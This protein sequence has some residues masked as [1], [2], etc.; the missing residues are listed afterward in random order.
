MTLSFKHITRVDG[1]IKVVLFHVMPT[2]KTAK[3]P[4]QARSVLFSMPADHI[5]FPRKHWYKFR[6]L[7]CRGR[8]VRSVDI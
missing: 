2:F 8:K 5:G 1:R 7:Y 3:Q 4:L 6:E